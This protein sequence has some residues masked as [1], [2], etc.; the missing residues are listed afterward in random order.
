MGRGGGGGWLLNLPTPSY[1]VVEAVE[2]LLIIGARVD[3]T[4][5]QTSQIR[6]G[7]LPPRSHGRLFIIT[8]I[9]SLI[10]PCFFLSAPVGA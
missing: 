10:R 9:I 7:P 1:T 2:T 3:S 5:L 6:P 4:P 8:V